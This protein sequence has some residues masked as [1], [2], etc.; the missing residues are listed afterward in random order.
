MI[1]PQISFELETRDSDFIKLAQRKH[2]ESSFI[3]VYFDKNS[4]LDS[5]YSRDLTQFAEL[6]IQLV[7]EDRRSVRQKKSIVL[8]DLDFD[9]PVR[10]RL[11]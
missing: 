5:L 2:L 10:L 6:T 4:I 3:E 9:A 11:F 8:K 7:S 1:L